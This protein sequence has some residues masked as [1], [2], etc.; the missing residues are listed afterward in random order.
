HALLDRAPRVPLVPGLDRDA[1]ADDR[2]ALRGAAAD[3]VPAAGRRLAGRRGGALGDEQ[4]VSVRHHVRLGGHG[5][6]G[7]GQA[8]GAG[9]LAA[10]AVLCGLSA[11]AGT[12]AMAF[13]TGAPRAVARVPASTVNSVPF[14]VNDVFRALQRPCPRAFTPRVAIPPGVGTTVGPVGPPRVP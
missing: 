8:G 13:G 7:R 14:M 11:A 5:R 3:L 9:R 6:G 2:A 12:R 10:A 1:L 4:R